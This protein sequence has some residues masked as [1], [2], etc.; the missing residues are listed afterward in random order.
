LET[1]HEKYYSTGFFQVFESIQNKIE[2]IICE[3]KEKDKISINKQ[4]NIL[5][6]KLQNGI[7]DIYVYGNQVKLVYDKIRDL[8]DDSISRMW[9]RICNS[10]DKYVN[11]I[12]EFP[13]KIF[14]FNQFQTLHNKLLDCYIGF[15]Y[16]TSVMS[17]MKNYPK[18]YF[19]SK[20]KIIIDKI[21]NIY[22]QIIQ[23]KNSEF[24]HP[25]NVL[26]YMQVIK[27]INAEKLSY[28]N[29]RFLDC[30]L[31]NKNCNE[32][33]C[34][35]MLNLVE[36]LEK[37]LNNMNSLKHFWINIMINRQN[38]VKDNYS[39]KYLTYLH[40]IQ[41]M[42]EIQTKTDEI[43]LISN[44]FDNF[45]NLSIEKMDLSLMNF[46]HSIKL[47]EKLVKLIGLL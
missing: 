37:N 23:L 28:F 11:A 32:E 4:I 40:K 30:I 12:N 2:E 15:D 46:N 13:D 35:D 14:D 17:E 5:M 45:V 24:N 20:R 38:Y 10:T 34:S 9:S 31:L 26:K 22:D 33:Y 16:L 3:N 47:E 43:K 25:N 36:F 42:I 18:K 8:K 21:N 29:L 1:N 6:N 44:I 41:D 7:D 19:E 39:T 27:T